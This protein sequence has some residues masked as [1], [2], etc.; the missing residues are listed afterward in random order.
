MKFTDDEVIDYVFDDLPAERASQIAKAAVDDEEL[1]S[2]IAVLSGFNSGVVEDRSDVAGHPNV[3]AMP[4]GQQRLSRAMVLATAAMVFLAFGFYL[5]QRAALQTPL[6][7]FSDYG[8]HVIAKPRQRMNVGGSPNVIV[9]EEGQ[10][11]VRTFFDLEIK[12]SRSGFLT[13]ILLSKNSAAIWPESEKE[14]LQL[15]AFVATEFGPFSPPSDPTYVVLVITETLQQASL[16]RSLIPQISGPGQ[17]LTTF[18][19]ALRQGVRQS[20]APWIAISSIVV[21]KMPDKQ[22]GDQSVTE[23]QETAPP[24]LVQ[25]QLVAEKADGDQADQTDQL[26]ISN[27]LLLTNANGEQAFRQGNFAEAE[28][29]FRKALTAAEKLYPEGHQLVSGISSSLGAALMRQFRFDEARPHFTRAV[30]ID[31]RLAVDQRGHSNLATSLNNLA[32][33]LSNQRKFEESEELFREAL[34]LFRRVHLNGHLLIPSIGNNLGQSLK[35]QGKLAQAK[36]VFRQAIDDTRRVTPDE[37]TASTSE[38][39]ARVLSNL[40]TVYYLEGD[41]DDARA[42]FERALDIRKRIHSRAYPITLNNLASLL[43]S[44][45]EYHQAKDTFYEV[46]R[47]RAENVPNDVRDRDL[48]LANTL[49]N[50]GRVL[51]KL[52][53]FDLAQQRLDHALRILHNVHP[54][55]NH[56]SFLVSFVNLGILHRE[57][58]NFSDAIEFLRKAVSLEEGLGAGMSHPNLAIALNELG[59]V[60]RRRKSYPEA[61]QMFTRAERILRETFTAELYPRGHPHLAVT[62]ENTGL[63]LLGAGDVVAGV[64]SLYDSMRMAHACAESFLIAVSEAEALNFASRHLRPSNELLSVWPQTDRAVDDLYALIWSYKGLIHRIL[65][66]RQQVLQDRQDD[67]T[68]SLYEQWLDVRRQLAGQ[69]LAP[70][71]LSDATKARLRKLSDAKEGLERQ[72]AGRIEGFADLLEHK[73]RSH[74]ELVKHLPPH[75]VY[76]DFLEYVHVDSTKNVPFSERRYLAFVIRPDQPV[77]LVPLAESTLIEKAIRQWRSSIE[78]AEETSADNDLR[79][80]VWTPLEPY[81]S[82]DTR[83]LIMCPDGALSAVPWGALPGHEKGTV[84]LE[85]YG[86]ALSPHGGFFLERIESPDRSA[87]NQD[88]FLQVQNVAYGAQ[89][90]DQRPVPT[91]ALSRDA[92]SASWPPL[93]I[94]SL[95]LSLFSSE[96]RVIRLADRDASTYRV[97]ETLRRARWAHFATHGFF[98]DKTVRSLLQLP[99]E[100]F[101]RPHF[102]LTGTRITTVGRNPL[103]MSGLVLAGAN[104]PRPSDAFGPQGDGGILSAEAIA[105]LPLRNLEFVGLWACDTGVG[106][107]AGGE[108]VF[109]LQRA[110]HMAGAHTTLGSLWKVDAKATST[111]MNRFYDNYLNK[112]MT[113][114]DA[115]RSAQLSLRANPSQGSFPFFWAAWMLSGDPS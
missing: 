86:F 48:E 33:L 68:K 49:N 21:T 54:D 12:S 1:A 31:R 67:A 5:W 57:Q 100:V 10:F 80:L 92:D 14:P 25:F 51:T 16:V 95:D 87:S 52:R 74:H 39:Y 114:L 3:G 72:L 93:P 9:D 91:R 34:E 36:T 106:D 69:A 11:R 35:N 17:E 103:L 113:K 107:V 81:L 61:Q 96:Q 78:G 44:Q 40:G 73:R 26:R 8:A 62:M 112:R 50:L 97:V 84:L 77:T 43:Y 20:G 98:A 38:T 101:E 2:M 88:V 75:I 85:K 58:G 55:V 102:P 30:E 71:T 76:I 24:E 110:F 89:P 32:T 15:T 94:A 28:K 108:G 79:Q 47:L 56:R 66:Q 104:L 111:I 82:K 83:F 37:H 46:V 29:L 90:A 45:G 7:R 4:V 19:D 99:E 13:V 22:L 63:S 6:S 105:G 23:P 115:L 18:T 41:Y 64:N 59:E 53:E 27:E 70:G 42:L 60:L 65:A 109:S